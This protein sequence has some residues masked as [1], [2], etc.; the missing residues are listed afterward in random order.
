MNKKLQI[1]NQKIA[2][3]K[4]LLVCFESQL[5]SEWYHVARIIQDM[6]S[7]KEFDSIPLWKFLDFVAMFRSVQGV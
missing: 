2:G 3:L 1:L 7:H 5:H 6:S 4:I